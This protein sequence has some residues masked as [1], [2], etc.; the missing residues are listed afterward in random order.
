MNETYNAYRWA[1]VR[2]W[3]RHDWSMGD[4]AKITEH[5]ASVRTEKVCMTL[6]SCKEWRDMHR[7]AFN[8]AMEEL[9]ELMSA[10]AL[11]VAEREIIRKLATW[12][13]S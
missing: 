5:M 6:P 7:A 8:V 4:L 12:V 1:F 3:V 13:D 11:S 9:E 2:M 10:R